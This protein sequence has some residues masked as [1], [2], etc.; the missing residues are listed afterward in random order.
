MAKIVYN[1]LIRDKIP[2]VIERA[3]KEFKTRVLND[4]EYIEK[5]LEKINEETQELIEAKGREE[6]INEIADVYE[7][8]EALMAVKNISADEV[9]FTKKSKCD[10]SGAFKEKLLLIEVDES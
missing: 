4:E 2:E 10:K 9:K 3:G 7:V 6:I 5:V 1:K 8:I